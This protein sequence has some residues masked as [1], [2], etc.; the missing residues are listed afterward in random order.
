M[1]CWGRTNGSRRSRKEVFQR[2]RFGASSLVCTWVA[3]VTREFEVRDEA[4]DLTRWTREV[5]VADLGQ[6]YR[7]G[8]RVEI[9]YVLQRHRPKSY[10]GGA[11]ARVMLES[12]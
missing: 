11:E 6:Y 3:W 12:V 8:C 9:E 2:T 10:D 7:P 4:G 1:V 5:A